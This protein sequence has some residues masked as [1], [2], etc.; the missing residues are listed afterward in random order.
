MDGMSGIDD[1]WVVFIT[2]VD[3]SGTISAV[4]ETFSSRGVSF[5]S[6]NTLD[7]HDGRGRL[8]VT[9]RGSPRIAR[10]LVRTLERLIV[11]RAVVLMRA[12]D[13]ALQA[14]AVVSGRVEGVDAST[15]SAW[16]D[17]RV[18]TGSFASVEEAVAAAR[19]TGAVI[20]AVT[21]VPPD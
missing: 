19:A 9:F 3:R 7:V 21:V 4:T 14:V 6:L 11:V 8:S 1:R 17:L 10:E 20:R 2:A 18:V 16:D 15:V 13:S 12:E 5:E